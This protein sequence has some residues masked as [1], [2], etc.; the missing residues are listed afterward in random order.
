[1]TLCLTALVPSTDRHDLKLC[2]CVSLPDVRPKGNVRDTVPA[3]KRA[4]RGLLHP[5]VAWTRLRSYETFARA[6]SS[7]AGV[8]HAQTTTDST[9]H[10]SATDILWLVR[11]APAQVCY[12]DRDRLSS[13]LVR[14][15]PRPPAGRSG[16]CT[17]YTSRPR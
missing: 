11:Q 7:D 5:E 14:H 15:D 8:R 2:G 1:M 6:C 17:Q 3:H 16:L 9:A 10:E 12:R 13:P 4:V